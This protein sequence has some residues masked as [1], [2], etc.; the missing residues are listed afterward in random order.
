MRL[1]HTSSIRE[2][3]NAYASL[4]LEVE[5]MSARDRLFHFINKLQSWAQEEL[6]WREV[7][8]VQAAMEAAILVNN[9]SNFRSSAPRT[10]FWKP[11]Q[12]HEKRR[13]QKRKRSPEERPKVVH[14]RKSS[15]GGG[16]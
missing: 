2:Y 13:F 4:M 16:A 9:N 10:G 3:T 7:K 14:P 12:S 15:T 8:N 1:R 5:E 6:H 11:S